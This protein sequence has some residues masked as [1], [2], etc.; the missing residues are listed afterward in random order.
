M[1]TTNLNTAG[2]APELISVALAAK[3]RQ[4]KF[5]QSMAAFQALFFGLLAPAAPDLLRNALPPDWSDVVHI[6]PGMIY[7]IAFGA[8]GL[9]A[10]AW[11]AAHQVQSRIDALIVK[12]TP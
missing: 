8:G 5:L 12:N 3:H 2:L 10:F 6:L 1:F 11:Y 7:S 4:L 9:A